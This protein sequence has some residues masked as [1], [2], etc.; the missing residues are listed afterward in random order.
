MSCKY[1]NVLWDLLVIEAHVIWQC[2]LQDLSH[3]FIAVI[4]CQW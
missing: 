1:K 4:L 3:T 2:R